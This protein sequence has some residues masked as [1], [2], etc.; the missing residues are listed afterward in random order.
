VTALPVYR[1]ETRFEAGRLNIARSGEDAMLALS[2]RQLFESLAVITAV[3][4]AL[5][6]VGAGLGIAL[7]YAAS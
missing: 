3:S 6:I 7:L 5:L 2:I 4:A 1:I